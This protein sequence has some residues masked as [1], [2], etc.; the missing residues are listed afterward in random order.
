[1][2]RWLIRGELREKPMTV[3]NRFHS[4]IMVRAAKLLDNWLDTQPEP[5]GSVL[6]G[7]AG[8]KL[9]RNPD[10]TVGIDVVYISAEVAAAQTDETTLIEGVPILAV[11]ILSPNDVVQDIDNKIAEYLA[12][13][14][15]L[16]WVIDPSDRTVLVYQPREEPTL[17]NVK[18]E[19][20]AEPHLPG[21]RIAVARLF[22]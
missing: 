13:G 9:R 10:T 8:C 17:F 3:R 11:E 15:A 14:V 22:D 6:G 19:L 16:I 2:D 20:T 1:M 21:F 5:R 4:R 18:Q 7:E 12:A